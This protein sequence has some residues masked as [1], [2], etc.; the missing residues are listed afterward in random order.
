MNARQPGAERLAIALDVPGLDAAAPLA[1]ALEGRAAVLKIGLE[2]FV[3]HGP[4]AVHF[5]HERGFD[6]FLDLKLHDIPRTVAAAV[7]SASSLGVSLLT[8]HA[9]GGP[10]MIAA[11]REAAEASGAH[12]PKLLAVTV[13]T[14]HDAT[15]LAH[16]GLASPPASEVV[17]L[18]RMALDA[19]ADGLVAS[20][21]EARALRA[22]AGPAAL[23]VTPGIRP[24]GADTQDQKRVA[25]PASAIADGAS[26]LVIGRPILAAPDPRAAADAILEEIRAA[27]RSAS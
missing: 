22:L 5:A 14:S 4:A 16:I 24:A 17:R 10:A 15:E 6:V 25:T 13:L 21:Q 11:A 27:E 7:T 26:L 1:V 23:I 12:R 8:L 20:A 18:A 2:L 19:G 9:L 3:K